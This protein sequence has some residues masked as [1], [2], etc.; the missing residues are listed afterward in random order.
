MV[1]RDGSEFIA[2]TPC[3]ACPSSDGFALYDDGHGYCFSCGHY[4]GTNQHTEERSSPKVNTELVNQGDNRALAKRH[5]T[6]ETTKRFDYQ[7][8]KFKGKTVQIANYKNNSGTTVAQKLRFPNKDFLFIGDT[9]EAGL[10]GQWMWRDGG[11]RL[12]VVEGEIDCL[13]V[14]QVIGKNWPVV[15][16]P[17][18][19]K[20]AKKAMQKQLEW[21]CKFESV[22]LMFDSDDAG[23][24]AAKECAGLFPAGKAKIALLPR[25]DANEMLVAGDTKEI[26]NAMFDAKPFRPDGIV[27][28]TELWDVVTSEDNTVSFDYPYAGLNA[29]TLGLRKGEIVTVTA[30]SGIGKS[31]LCREFSHFLLTQGETVGYIA[32]E[33][34]VKRTSLGLM[35]LAI[36]KPL[37]LGTV[38]VSQD[39]LKE[40]FDTTLGTGR[41]FLYDHWGSTDSQNLMDKIRYLASG[42]ECGWVILDHISIVVS[43]MEGGDE[44][45]LI[46]NTMT[47]C[48][49]LVEELKI[50]LILVSHLKR[51]EGKGHEEGGRTTLAQ[52]RGSAGIA[53]LSDI[54][55]GCERDQQD[56]ETGN[57][58]VVRVLKNRWTGETGVGCLLE[59][60]KYTGRMTEI[61]SAEFDDDDAVVKFP[62]ATSEF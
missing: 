19:S 46:D 34:S 50:G 12:V 9:K 42:C 26:T 51:P 53:Q 62:A 36:N 61:S 39:E 20:G 41:V 35:S 32:L 10:Y 30:G 18:G 60:D 58:T 8:G 37:H 40:A 44:R 13:S 56:Q 17:T 38:E 3:P 16:V 22:I 48:R 27:N 59:Y 33:E 52:L 23:K 45:R 49:A 7:I 43:G 55:L 47:K 14:S 6:E 21:L 54:V 11:K 31:Q 57:M 25:K 2:H 15:S 4:E 1:E 28:G 5:I 29:K 24:E